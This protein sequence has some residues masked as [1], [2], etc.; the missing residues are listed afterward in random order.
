MQMAE[1]SLKLMDLPERH[2]ANFLQPVYQLTIGHLVD[3]MEAFADRNTELAKSLQVKDSELDEL[4]K[5]CMMKFS[6][7]IETGNANGSY[8]LSLVFVLRSLERI[9]DLA[10]NIGK[11]VCFIGDLVEE[12]DMSRLS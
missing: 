6:D 10:S 1:R 9:N 5:R 7:L 3:S 4:F 2:E 11:D 12:S 8:V